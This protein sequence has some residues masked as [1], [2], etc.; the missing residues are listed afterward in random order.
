MA[1]E[2]IHLS[3]N[4]AGDLIA[5]VKDDSG[6]LLTELAVSTTVVSKKRAKSKKKSS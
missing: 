6:K 2:V 5:T 1:Q 3:R 4:D